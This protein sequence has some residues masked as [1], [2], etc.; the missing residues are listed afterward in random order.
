MKQKDV[1]VLQ[2]PWPYE[3]GP[4][5]QLFYEEQN[6]WIDTDYVFM[7]EITRTKYKKHGLVEAASF[8]FPAANTKEHIRPMARFMVWLTLFDDYH[9]LC[10]VNKLAPIRDHVMDIMMGAKPNPDDIGL[11][12]Q[13]ALSRQEFLPYVNDEW[14]ERWT[15]S[16]YN[17]ITYGVIEETSY[18]VKKEIPTLHNLLLIREYSIAMYPYG[19]PVEPAI[20]YIVP[21]DISGHPIIQR[22]KMLM[23]RIIAIQNDFGSI[24]KELPVDTEILNIILVIKNQYKI[25][26]EEAISEATH[27]HDTYVKEFVELQNNLPD[28]GLHQK[29]IERFIHNIAL[30]ISGLGA[31]Y[32][33]GQ[34]TRYKV[35]GE[36]P[37]P[38]YGLLT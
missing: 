1:P 4:F 38:E 3:I 16:F 25:S 37:K 20:S 31:W 24:Q 34:S 23:C 27:I 21:K 14:F 6:D 35:P 33:K 13:V 30:M 5:S 10:P 12:R 22:L 18:K 26:L 29:N 2:Y 32:H 17:Y 7:S 11:M 19:D 28:F 36:F 8:M 15:K 9:E